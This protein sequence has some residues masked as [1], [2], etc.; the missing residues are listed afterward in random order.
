MTL[1]STIP[2]MS[3]TLQQG[4]TVY[5]NANGGSC[6][7]SSYTTTDYLM[8][9][10]EEWNTAQ[11]G[12]GTTYYPSG[13]YTQNTILKLYAQWNSHTERGGVSLPTPTKTGS[14][15]LG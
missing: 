6:P 14:T 7:V 15:F 1:S 2:T 13:T 12:S 10:F 5:F 4:Y 11:D 9:S 3:S 8:H